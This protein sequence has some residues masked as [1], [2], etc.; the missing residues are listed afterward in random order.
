MSVVIRYYLL[1]Q[2]VANLITNAHQLKPAET[3]TVSTLVLLISLVSR[4]LHARS[5]TIEPDVNVLQ[6]MKEMDFQDVQR[7]EKENVNTTSIVQITEHV[8]N[9]NVWILAIY[10]T[11]VVSKQS[12]RRHLIDLFVDVHQ[13]GEEIL[14]NSVTSMNAEKTLI[15]HLIKLV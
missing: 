14:T 13:D 5:T 12:V 8:F 9:T 2:L 7:S 1:N 6:G 15:V 11:L 10:L 4:L 3:G